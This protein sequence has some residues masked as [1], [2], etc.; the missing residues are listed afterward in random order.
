MGAKKMKDSEIK[1]KRSF[2]FWPSKDIKPAGI[3]A[4]KIKRR[5]IRKEF[6]RRQWIEAHVF[7]IR[8]RNAENGL[9]R[10]G[11]PISG[12]RLVDGNWIESGKKAAAN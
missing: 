8:Q 9:N 2:R 10:Y 12:M 3:N 5:Q 1:P 11:F 4:N 6:T 7:Q